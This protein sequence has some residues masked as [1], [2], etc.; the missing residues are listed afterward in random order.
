LN[1]QI[2]ERAG[3]L[4]DN[5]GVDRLSGKCAIEIYYVQAPRTFPMPTRSHRN[6]IVGKHGTVVH[7]SL[8]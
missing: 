2:G 8:A 7:I 3:D 1:R 5:T 6:G 4:L